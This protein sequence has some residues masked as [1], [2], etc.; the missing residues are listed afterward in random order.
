MKKILFA[1]FTLLACNASAQ[2]MQT[3]GTLYKEHPYIDVINKS[4]DYFQKQDWVK[5]GALYADT[6]KFYDN[7][8][9]YNLAAA[10]KEWA[11]IFKDWDKIKV[12]KVGYPDGLK[13][14]KEGFTVQ[15]WWHCTCVNKKTK[16]AAAFEQVLFDVFNKD[17]KITAEISYYDTAPLLAAAK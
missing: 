17:G 3:N 12:T 6:A 13:Y 16:K 1:V 2:K 15:S 4:V 9:K 7:S 8:R 14:N 10:K 5:L 11:G